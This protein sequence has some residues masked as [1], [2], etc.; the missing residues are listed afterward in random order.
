MVSRLL[1]KKKHYLFRIVLLLRDVLLI[2]S[3]IQQK[4]HR[5]SVVGL[6]HCMAEI[7]MKNTK[8]LKVHFDKTLI[9]L[10]YH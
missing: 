2:R 6:L 10:V 7:R 3:P 8:P 1:K 9:V 4:S 5:G